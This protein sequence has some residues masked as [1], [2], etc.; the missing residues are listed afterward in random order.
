MINLFQKK[1]LKYK[2]KYLNLK[3]NNIK[4]GGGG[5]L[6]TGFSRMY[7]YNIS[8][9][10]TNNLINDAINMN[11]YYN[12]YYDINQNLIEEGINCAR[13]PKNFNI[14]NINTEKLGINQYESSLIYKELVLINK[15]LEIYSVSTIQSSISF[16]TKE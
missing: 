10:I 6:Y 4:E 13:G 7:V 2:N 11:R 3:L 1:Y 16:L 9:H 14:K 5:A 12:K 8:L 15:Y